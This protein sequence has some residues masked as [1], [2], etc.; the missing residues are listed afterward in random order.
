MNILLIGEFSGLHN[1]LREGLINLGH[2]VTLASSGDGWKKLKSDIYFCRNNQKGLLAKIYKNL[3]PFWKIRDI[4]NYDIVQ[5]INFNI[6]NRKINGKFLEF[7]RRKNKNLFFTIAGN[8]S[9]VTN[10]SIENFEY[11][12]YHIFEEER[13]YC[14]DIE[15]KI[16]I[17][18]THFE[19]QREIK[20]LEMAKRV[21]PTSYSYSAPFNRCITNKAP[22]IMMPINTDKYKEFPLKKKSTKI[23]I[24]YG[25][26]RKC[27]KGHYF[28]DS[29]LRK[30]SKDF[31]GLVEIDRVEKLSFCD[32][33]SKIEAC[34]FLIDQCKSMGY[35]MN[36]LIGM[37][38]G[39][40]VFS[41]AEK[42]A[43]DHMGISQCPII[44][45]KPCVDDIYIKIRELVRNR[46]FACQLGHQSRQ[47]A[48][49]FH[50]YTHIAEKYIETWVG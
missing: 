38:H 44:N 21:I 4:E 28:I 7:L 20:A 36:A 26:N 11:S 49:R 42:I 39:K 43:L 27:D 23:H 46:P 13:S 15:K 35:G 17:R 14:N 47:Y 19:I 10:Y 32:Y 41:G 1:N 33:I 22:L 24:L 12:P 16:A 2:R 25:I 5:A 30:I 40:V 8:S 29:A 37:A 18:K 48:V 31:S 9:I 6:I 3:S 45:I 50:N 34:D